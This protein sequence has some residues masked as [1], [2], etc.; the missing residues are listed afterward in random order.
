[1]ITF[2]TAEYCWAVCV[3][4]C[5]FIVLKLILY[6]DQSPLYILNPELVHRAASMHQV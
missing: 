2:S 6:I 3:W 5:V 1:M 4:I